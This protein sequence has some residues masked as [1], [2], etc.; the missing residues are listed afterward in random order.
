ME[1]KTQANKSPADGKEVAD[2]QFRREIVFGDMIWIKLHGS[3]WWPA[4]VCECPQ[5]F[6]ASDSNFKFVYHSKFSFPYL[7]CFI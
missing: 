4:Q 6:V 7:Q 3:S 1:S 2:N 5:H